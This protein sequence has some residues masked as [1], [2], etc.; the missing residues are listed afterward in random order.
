MFGRSTAASGE[1]LSTRDVVVHND[2]VSQACGARKTTPQWAR[3]K[4]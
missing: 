1:M 4:A 2:H 3:I